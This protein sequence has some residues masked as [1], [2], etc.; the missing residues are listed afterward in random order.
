MLKTKQK[1]RKQIKDL[2]TDFEVINPIESKKVLGGDWYNGWDSWYYDQDGITFTYG[3]NDDWNM[4]PYGNYND[5]GTWGEDYGSSGGGGDNYGQDGIPNLP[6][7][8]EQQLG[9][10]GACVSYAMAYMSS[11]LGHTITGANMA[12]QNAQSLNLSVATTMING[13][14]ITQATQAIQSYFFTTTLTTTA[15]IINAVET[16]QHGVLTNVYVTDSNGNNIPNLGHEVVIVDYNPGT[17]TFIAADSSTGAYE[18]YNA[19]QINLGGGIHEITGV[20]P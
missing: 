14:T 3:G 8:V 17:N 15:Q 19:N 16:N 10:M 6:T 2:Q 7:T 13:L 9:S 4:D 12:L 20:K 5:P 18:T 1:R 11:Y